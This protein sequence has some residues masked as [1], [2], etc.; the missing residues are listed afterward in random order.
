MVKILTTKLSQWV[1]HIT[2]SPGLVFTEVVQCLPKLNCYNKGGHVYMFFTN[3]Y[4]VLKAFRN[5]QDQQVLSTYYHVVPVIVGSTSNFDMTGLEA[6]SGCIWQGLSCFF[7]IFL[8]A[9]VISC[10][11]NVLNHIYFH[12]QRD[13]DRV[14]SI[15]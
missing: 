15:E 2:R 11:S 1:R 9:P 8:D 14:T 10:N 5:Q 7:V 13:I 4:L 6:S 12:Q 3:I